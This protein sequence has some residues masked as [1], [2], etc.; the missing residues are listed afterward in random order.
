MFLAMRQF[1]LAKIAELQADGSEVVIGFEQPL[2]P[3]PFLKKGVII[4]PT[5]IDTT[6]ILQGLVAIIQGV[7]EELGLRYRRYDM[8]SLKKELAGFGGADK[9][10]MVFVA[11]KVGL[12]I[13]V[14]DEADAFAG[15]LLMMREFNKAAS[16]N[17]DRLIWSSRGAL[18]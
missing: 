5:S 13:E 15:F 4:Y 17:F 7:A 3:K 10:D 9:T 11:R 18:L 12:T 8:G 1:L 2:L 6:L 16:A 14:H